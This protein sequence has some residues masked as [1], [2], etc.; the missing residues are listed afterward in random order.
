MLKKFF[1]IG[2]FIF[3]F[4]IGIK[5]K[6]INKVKNGNDYISLQKNELENLKNYTS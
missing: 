3:I 5:S 2:L 1:K 6:M 4:T